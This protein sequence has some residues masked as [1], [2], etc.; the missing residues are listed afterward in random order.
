MP[1]SRTHP[2]TQRARELASRHSSSSAFV[3]RA[4]GR[5]NLIGEH[6]DYSGYSVLPMAI[7]QDVLISVEK[8][9]QPNSDAIHVFSEGYDAQTFPSDPESP[10]SSDFSYS[11]YCHA[12]YKG[13]FD[14]MKSQGVSRPPIIAM[15][16]R[17]QGTVPHSAGLSSSSALVVASCLATLTAHGIDITP[18]QLASVSCACEK[19]VGTC[20]GGMDQAAS[21]LCEEG[22]AL[23]IEFNP[24]RSAKVALPPGGVFVISHS[25]SEAAKAIA[26]EKR[27]N[28]RAAEVRLAA[29]VNAKRAGDE[30]WQDAKR[31][32]D[33]EE[34]ARRGRLL[35]GLGDFAKESIVKEL[36][37]DRVESI[38][39]EPAALLRAWEWNET[40]ALG[41]RAKHVYEEASRVRRF[42][43]VCGDPH[44]GADEKLVELGSLMTASHES[45]RDL[46]DCS[47]AELDKLTSLALAS[48]ALGSR[49][50][51][52]GWGGCAV[53][54]VR[55]ENVD[56]FLRSVADG[57]Y[58]TSDIADLERRGVLF[59]CKPGDGACVMR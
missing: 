39:G 55:Q 31:L 42:R 50:T 10:L 16:W 3:V 49:L 38:V 14:F 2:L 53:S 46:Y 56:S 58:G 57:F 17:I 34:S 24:L 7:S 29:A 8:E 30:S 5:V 40:F 47:C 35:D 25:L 23:H 19:Y 11:H 27:F 15:S 1:Y 33:V 43:D 13:A 9:S 37:K 36:G 32:R 54:L 12:G 48:G 51:G 18:S 45:C 44:L 21:C 6:I 41:S 4:P 28:K 59:A 22:V 26:P 20:G 52:A